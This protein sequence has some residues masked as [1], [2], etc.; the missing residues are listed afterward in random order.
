M[1]LENEEGIGWMVITVKGR[2]ERIE[3]CAVAD[4]GKLLREATN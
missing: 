2:R 4:P 3:L 1:V